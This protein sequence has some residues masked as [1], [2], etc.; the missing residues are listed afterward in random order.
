MSVGAV[1]GAVKISKTGA[2]CEANQC[3][4]SKLARE[5]IP[6]YPNFRSKRVIHEIYIDENELFIKARYVT[7]WS[8]IRSRYSSRDD[9]RLLGYGQLL[10]PTKG[11]SFQGNLK[12]KERDWFVGDV[13]E[14]SDKATT[15]KD[16]IPRNSSTSL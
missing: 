10:T 11:A 4:G 9:S 2:W 7:P 8:V 3:S 13:R 12:W 1:P 6:R 14:L 16:Y 15:F 5:P